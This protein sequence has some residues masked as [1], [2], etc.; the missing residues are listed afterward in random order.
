MVLHFKTLWHQC[1]KGG[2]INLFFQSKIKEE[3]NIQMGRYSIEEDNQFCHKGHNTKFWSST[4]LITNTE[5]VRNREHQAQWHKTSEHDTT[6]HNQLQGSH[7]VYCSLQYLFEILHM[8]WRMESKGLDHEWSVKCFWHSCQKGRL[9][10]NKKD[11]QLSVITLNHF[12]HSYRAYRGSRARTLI[13]AELQTVPSKLQ[14]VPSKL[15][16]VP[17]KS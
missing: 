14:T 4:F 3:D 12:H 7:K 5:Q 17:R 10:I 2:D 9:L 15:Q 1:Q 16:T 13:D 6:R 8:N 11:W